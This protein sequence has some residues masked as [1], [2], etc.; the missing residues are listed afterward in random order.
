MRGGKVE[1]R[2]RRISRTEQSPRPARECHR[3]VSP[4]S[5]SSAIHLGMRVDEAGH[6]ET[7]IS[8]VRCTCSHLQDTWKPEWAV[9]KH[10]SSRYACQQWSMNSD[11][12]AGPGKDGFVHL[13]QQCQLSFALTNCLH[14]CCLQACAQDDQLQ[15]T[16]SAVQVALTELGLQKVWITGATLAGH[17]LAQRPLP[18]DEDIDL[19]YAPS[20]LARYWPRLLKLGNSSGWIADPKKQQRSKW[21]QLSHEQWNQKTHCQ[22]L[23]SG[24]HP[25]PLDTRCLNRVWV[26]FYVFWPE[27]STGLLC[28][29]FHAAPP[30][31]VSHE[32]TPAEGGWKCSDYF[33]RFGSYRAKRLDPSA[34]YPL[35]KERCGNSILNVPHNPAA[36]IHQ[37]NG[38]RTPFYG[39]GWKWSAAGN[40]VPSL[41]Q[42]STEVSQFT[43]TAVTK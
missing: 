26:D 22:G 1:R 27:P 42:G 37:Y 28:P 39:G 14:T 6:S 11:W 12:G 40:P 23:R 7:V 32:W 10:R 3:E 13:N 24:S 31:G 33:N 38:N 5:G 15:R 20:H 41:S 34:V 35:H 43:S 36:A 17:V 30:S 4:V 8:P 9:Q 21:M 19:A 29:P 2:D 25:L 18:F 16:L